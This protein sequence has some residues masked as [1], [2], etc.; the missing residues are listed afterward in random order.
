MPL[1]SEVGL[2]PG[3]IVLAPPTERGIAAPTFRPTSIVAKRSSISEAAELLL[4]IVIV[5]IMLLLIWRSGYATTDERKTER[6]GRKNLRQQ[7]DH[8]RSRIQCSVSAYKLELTDRTPAM[9]DL[10]GSV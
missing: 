1:C 6:N 10:D 2:G 4:Q 9:K 3:N 7:D 5:C 8:R